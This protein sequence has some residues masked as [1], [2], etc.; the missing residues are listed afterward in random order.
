MV[1]NATWRTPYCRDYISAIGR[2]ATVEVIPF[3][4]YSIGKTER[5]LKC[6]EWS[7]SETQKMSLK[8]IRLLARLNNKRLTFAPAGKETEKLEEREKKTR[9]TLPLPCAEQGDYM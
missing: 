5:F 3:S 4:R 9:N 6:V 7:N 8:N 2:P 1:P